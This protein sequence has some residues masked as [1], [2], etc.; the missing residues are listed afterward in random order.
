MI[1]P[2]RDNSKKTSVT[3][4]KQ[5]SEDL[6]TI[7]VILCLGLQSALVIIP[8]EEVWSQIQAIREKYDP[9]F[10][11]WMPHINLWVDYLAWLISSGFILL[12]HFLNSLLL[13]KEFGRHWQY[14]LLSQ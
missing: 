9:N 13:L 5:R 12:C 7:T 11:I 6:V 4:K 8:P 14:F 2:E 10:R 1:P 3:S